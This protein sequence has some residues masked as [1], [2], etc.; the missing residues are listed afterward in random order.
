MV[1]EFHL[2]KS[3][4]QINHQFYHQ[5]TNCKRPVKICWLPQF[6]NILSPFYNRW[7]YF[8]TSFSLIKWEKKT[9]F[10]NFKNNIIPYLTKI[11]NEKIKTEPWYKRQANVLK[12]ECKS[13]D[14]IIAKLSR[15]IEILTSKKTQVISRDVQT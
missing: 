13:K 7:R 9:Y 4:H 1:N 14:M 8:K 3:H 15:T 6:Q 10:V 5:R 11:I 12:E 2:L